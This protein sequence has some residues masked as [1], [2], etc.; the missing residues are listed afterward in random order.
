MRTVVAMGDSVTY[1]Q[2]LPE[3]ERAWPAIVRRYE[4]TVAAVPGDTTRLALERFP[5][6]VQEAE[7]DAVII[8]FGHNDA[9]RWRSDRGLPRVSKDAYRANLAEM[10]DR[11]RAF[12]ARP[13]LA[14]ITPTTRS[15]ALA[16][17]CAIYDLVLREVAEQRGVPLIDVRST[18]LTYGEG[19][20][21]DGLHLNR[22]GHQ[23]YAD[24]VQRTL[25]AWR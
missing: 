8:Q 5:R 21:L 2:L 23:L 25:D 1:G 17:D 15:D 6:D 9:N 19:L 18:F 12:G 20:L 4:I 3:G 7:P 16:A 14:T 13:F 24:S 11:C 22:V 10:V